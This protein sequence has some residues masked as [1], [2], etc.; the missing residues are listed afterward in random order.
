LKER[1]RI[2]LEGAK[3]LQASLNKWPHI[4]KL[5]YKNIKCKLRHLISLTWLS[6]IYKALSPALAVG[7]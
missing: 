7:E 3:P 5:E 1:G 2:V 6:F 4:Y